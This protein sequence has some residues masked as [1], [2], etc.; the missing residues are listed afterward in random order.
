[1]TAMPLE[2]TS[3][4]ILIV[5]AEY[6]KELADRLDQGAREVLAASGVP[7]ERTLMR[8]VPGCWELPLAVRRLIRRES[9]DAVIALGVLIQGETD[10]YEHIA[11]ETCAGLMQVSLEEGV[12]VA[13]GVLT[14][15]NREQ[16]EGRCGMKKSTRNKGREAAYAVLQMLSDHQG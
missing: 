8:R 7:G 14:C 13:L 4:K 6:Y 11:R 16:A 1:M 3:L 2:S 10:H 12:H 9:P 15:R 5:T